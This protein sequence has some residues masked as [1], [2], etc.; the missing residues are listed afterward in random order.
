VLVSGLTGEGL[1]QLLQRVAATLPAPPVEVRLLVPY[2][3]QRVV[4]RLY[5]EAEVLESRTDAEGTFLLARVRE[6]Q[7]DWVREFAAAPV[8]TRMT[9]PG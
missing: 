5:E 8:R 3:A 9:L 6:D 4:A 1:E 2:E 7:L